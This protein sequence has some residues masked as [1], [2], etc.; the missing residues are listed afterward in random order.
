MVVV[1]TTSFCGPVTSTKYS[2]MT[3][4][5]VTGGFFSGLAG[6]FGMKTATYASA[7]TANAARQSLD[8]GLKVA[9][10][11]GAVGQIGEKQRQHHEY[12]GDDLVLLAQVGHGAPAHVPG[13]LAHARR[14]L[15]PR[16]S[17]HGKTPKPATGR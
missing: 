5:N 9:F 10:R 11:T 3:Y 13:D 12:D 6:Y 17:S 16:A 8:R 4:Q 2:R 15:H 14:S 1:M 7:R